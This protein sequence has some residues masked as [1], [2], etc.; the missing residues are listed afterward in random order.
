MMAVILCVLAAFRSS[1]ADAQAGRRI[2]TCPCQYEAWYA[3]ASLVMPLLVRHVPQGIPVV[4]RQ[5]KQG[6]LNLLHRRSLRSHTYSLFVHS[7]T[8]LCTQPLN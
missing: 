1:R 5:P 8:P 2:S 4:A 3:L 7:L 6:Y